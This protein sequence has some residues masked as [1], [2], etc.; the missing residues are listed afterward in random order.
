MRIKSGNVY[1]RPL[2][3]IGH[4]KELLLK[5]MGLEASSASE[6]PS[7]RGPSPCTQN[8]VAL[9]LFAP[10]LSFNICVEFI[11]TLWLKKE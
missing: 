2:Q 9:G 4:N 7:R 5:T 1:K 10:L 8:V 3:V 11:G 6:A